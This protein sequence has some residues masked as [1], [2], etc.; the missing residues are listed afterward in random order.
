MTKIW[1]RIFNSFMALILITI[2]LTAC[3]KG[4][5]TG[6][7]PSIVEINN[8]LSEAIDL[9]KMDN[10]D[11]EVLEKFYD[12]DSNKLEEFVLYMPKTNIE[13]NEIAI[14]KVKNTSDLEDIKEKIE[15]RIEEQGNAFRDYIPEEYY[16]I[17]NHVLKTKDNYILFAI[18]EDVDKIEKVFDESFK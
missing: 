11:G 5:S 4:G 6:K 13:V 8:K 10:G 14:L 17:E 2:V 16:L 3:T 7:N 18:Y 9:S 12:I 1:K 15:N